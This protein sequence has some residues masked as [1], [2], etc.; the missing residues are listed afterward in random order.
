MDSIRSYL[1]SEDGSGD[2]S[3]DGVSGE[4]HESAGDEDGAGAGEGAERDEDEGVS[5][6]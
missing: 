3:D 6:D 4:V 1:V 5:D 2:A